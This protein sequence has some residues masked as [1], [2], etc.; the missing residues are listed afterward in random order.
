MIFGSRET[1][2]D[3]VLTCLKDGPL[4]ILD[5]I[6]HIQKK[7]PSTTKQGVY[8]AIRNLKKSQI[9]VVEKGKASLNASWIKQMSQYFENVEHK[10]FHHP[11][12]RGNFS[13]LQEGDRVVYF[14]H[15]AITT[16]IF[17]NHVIIHL[18]HSS[19]LS[20]P[21]LAYSPHVWFYIAHQENELA[22]LNFTL[23]QNYQYLVTS[24]NNSPLD[25]YPK[26]FMDG[27][28]SQYHC[29]HA[30]IFKKSNYY[31]NII[32]DFL[33]EV[34]I[35]KQTQEKID[36]FYQEETVYTHDTQ[37]KFREIVTSRGKTKLKI[38]RNK[39]RAQRLSKK[40]LKNFFL[41]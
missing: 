34:Y 28:M 11:F 12:S 37:K 27:R 1:L 23:E 2:E 32:D 19:D 3:H 33:I 39:K 41:I 20:A 29:L 36:A 8:Y 9:I 17:W 35:D 22:L 38:S 30:P 40:L 16:D 10:Y 31:L 24:G 13:N 26:K 18:L 14:F 6:A 25:H 21:F 5:I 7:H 4:L 15:D